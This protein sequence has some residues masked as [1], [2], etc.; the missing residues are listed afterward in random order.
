MSDVTDDFELLAP[1]KDKMSMSP[2]TGIAAL[3]LNFALKYHDIN[4]VQDGTLYQQYKL[5]GRNFQNLQ[6]DMVFETAMRIEA[7]LV[8]S[9]ERIAA[10]VIECLETG[11][12]ELE[13]EKSEEASSERSEEEF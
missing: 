3:A 1:V 2:A 13:A 12:D 4:T 7:H 5:E 10:I 9:E 8:T 6:L 11:L